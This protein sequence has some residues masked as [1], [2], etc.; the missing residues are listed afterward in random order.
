M[1]LNYQYITTPSSLT[2]KL[3]NINIVRTKQNDA[4]ESFSQMMMMM[5]KIKNLNW[6]SILIALKKTTII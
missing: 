6:H 1:L 3:E 2:H 5:M 4:T